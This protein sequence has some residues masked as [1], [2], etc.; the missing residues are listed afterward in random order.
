MGYA[1]PV[2]LISP[3]TMAIILTSLIYNGKSFKYEYYF[4]RY[5]NV[6]VMDVND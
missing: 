4:T 2:I 5:R 1:L 3:V 6:F